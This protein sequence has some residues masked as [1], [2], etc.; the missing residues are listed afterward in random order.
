MVW[1]REPIKTP[2]RDIAPRKSGSRPPLSE[3]RLMTASRSPATVNRTPTAAHRKTG[4]PASHRKANSPTRTE[5]YENISPSLNSYRGTPAPFTPSVAF[6]DRNATNSLTKRAINFDSA[7]QKSS[8]IATPNDLTFRQ[9]DIIVSSP[10][11]PS[12]L[13][14]GSSSAIKRGYYSNYLAARSK[15]SLKDQRTSSVEHDL[16]STSRAQH[17]TMITKR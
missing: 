6:Y 7:V 15:S 16:I 1:G 12:G 14:D 10:V 4:F 2:Q 9:S 3:E 17:N 11:T 8:S 5:L 13:T